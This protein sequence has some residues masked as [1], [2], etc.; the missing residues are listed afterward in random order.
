MYLGMYSK[1][2]EKLVSFKM[3]AVVQAHDVASNFVTNN[4]VCNNLTCQCCPLLKED[5]QAVLT[6][7][8]SASE[9]INILIEEHKHCSI[10]R[11]EHMLDN[12]CDDKPKI[13]MYEC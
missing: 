9:I 11:Q 4:D 3:A 5:L 2:W 8:K 12:D 13:C 6:E 10:T 1:F 7:I